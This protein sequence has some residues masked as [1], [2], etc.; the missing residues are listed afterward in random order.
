[1]QMQMAQTTCLERKSRAAYLCLHQ[2]AC[3]RTCHDRLG[4]ENSWF[5]A[6]EI[7]FDGVCYRG[8]VLISTKKMLV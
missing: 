2:G 1:M 7:V 6:F 4:N 3:E 8:T 5:N